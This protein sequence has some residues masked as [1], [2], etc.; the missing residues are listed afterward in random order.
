MPDVQV[1][2]SLPI[3]KKGSEPATGPTAVEHLQ[4]MLNQRGGYP[5]LVEDGVFGAATE[6]SVK[7]YQHN[8]N[9]TVDG[10]VGKNT[11]K[12]LLSRWLLQSAPG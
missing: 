3:L 11:W 8:E 5:H 7:H 4:L 1:A 9:L 12:S 2:L 10:V 6:A